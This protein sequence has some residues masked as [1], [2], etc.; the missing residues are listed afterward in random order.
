MKN[1]IFVNVGPRETRVAVSESDQ[2]VELHIERSTERGVVGGIYQGRVTRVLPGM[3]AAFV[4]IGLERAGFLYVADYRS[5]L[6]DVDLD[7]DENGASSSSGGRNSGGGRRRSGAAQRGLTPQ[8]QDLLEEGREILVQVAKEP[9]GTKGAR[10]T[11]RISL[12]GRHLV[13]MPS[14]SR[15]GVSRRIEGDRERRRLRQIVEKHR[16]NK[17]LGFIVRTVSHGVSEADI[18]ADIE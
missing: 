16:T 15:V 10:I 5:D 13:L 12:A 4:D 14:V 9:L 18:K 1:E 7:D 6:D 17:E 2:V 8:I 11:S 3:Q